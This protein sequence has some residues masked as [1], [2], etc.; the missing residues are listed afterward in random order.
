MNHV[1]KLNADFSPLAVVT[2]TEAMELVLG[3]KA[4]VVEFVPDK[5]V[6]SEHLTLPWPA[7]IALKRYK[8]VRSRVKFS[9][10][11]VILR[12]FGKCSYCGATPRL[13]DGNIDLKMLTL[14]H[15]V[16]RAHADHGTVYLPW[17]KRQVNVTSWENATTACRDCNSRK[18]DRTPAQ[19]GMPLLFT[20]R[21]PTAA[22]VLRMS[23]A[24]L[25]SFPDSWRPYLPG[26]R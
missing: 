8:T 23:L 7:V 14:D 1:L 9:G 10:R 21:S 13:P 11:N 12:D 24:K 22:D 6:H 5:H 3:E 17:S 18:A 25:R 4:T 2:W 26:S 20:P 19:A 16:P 15:V